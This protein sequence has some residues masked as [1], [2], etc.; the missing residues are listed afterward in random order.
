MS[1][2]L[3]SAFNIGTSNIVFCTA[4]KHLHHACICDETMPEKPESLFNLDT[5]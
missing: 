4:Y 1:E 5:Y 2:K 3:K